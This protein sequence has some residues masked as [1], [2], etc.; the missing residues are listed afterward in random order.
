M[1]ISGLFE[2]LNIEMLR[3]IAINTN[4][5]KLERNADIRPM[6][7]RMNKSFN[8]LK[9]KSTELERNLRFLDK[10]K[11]KAELKEIIRIMQSDSYNDE[12][13]M[14]EV[15]LKLAKL[16]SK[17]KIAQE[18]EFN[19]G[20]SDR[21]NEVY[22]AAQE[23]R[24]ARGVVSDSQATVLDANEIREAAERSKRIET[25]IL[26]KKEMEREAKERAAR[27][28]QA[29]DK[30]RA[31][32]RRKKSIDSQENARYES[33]MARKIRALMEHFDEDVE[34]E[35]KVSI[36]YELQNNTYYLDGEP[37]IVSPER[38]ISLKD[39]EAYIKSKLRNKS[40]YGFLIDKYN[41]EE[42]KAL[43]YCDP[44]I[45]GI[46]LSKDI[47]LARDYIKQMAGINCKKSSPYVFD[48]TYDVRG[49]ES[50]KGNKLTFRERR[51]IRKTA[52]YSKNVA[53][54]LEDR[55]KLP[56]YATIP[57]IGA[58]AI[59]GIAGITAV[60]NGS[61]QNDNKE[62]TSDNSYSDT[63][64]PGTELEDDDIIVTSANTHKYEF[65]TENT[66]DTTYTT[67]TEATTTTVV[68]TTP[69]EE[70][71]TQQNQNDDKVVD[72]SENEV[73]DDG[74][75]DENIIIN[76]GDKVSVKEGLKYTADC[77]GGGNS[78]RIGAVSW[79]PATEYNI[80]RVAF[81]YQ[82]RILKIMNKGDQDVS[83]TLQDIANKNGISAEDITTS[84]LLS[85][86]PGI[87]DTGWANICIDELQNN[88]SKP[89][90]EQSNMIS[91]IDF[92]FDR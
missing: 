51:S 48:V 19:P 46:L 78:N 27:V 72:N 4:P 43:K 70:T 66:T 92:D 37:I 42:E 54:V 87:G 85:L 16:C 79:R 1:N 20:L 82:G 5:S 65:E 26:K 80:D 57:V 90:E 56:W 39:K 15:D 21:I 41:Y 35:D 71:T 69:K 3:I 88:I 34:H 77:L 61:N 40:E 32:Q 75:E 76:I 12:F 36:R 89:V 23:K 11:F 73:I 62:F 55:K 25:A 7:K 2:T 53:K 49:L 81:V 86:V 91:H 84:V 22:K 58:I 6:L 8:A 38:L 60:F 68:T 31:E 33:V 17:Y 74:I 9:N 83:K 67:T 24:R 63:V 52:K 45:I 10:I 29:I 47:R 50:S 30:K 18:E 13:K 44:Y 59:G 28:S 64:E 14:F